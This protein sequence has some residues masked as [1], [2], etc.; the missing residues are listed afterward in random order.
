M[1]KA[2][3]T[4][5]S[6]RSQPLPESTS[7]TPIAP[8]PSAPSSCRAEKSSHDT[9]ID[10]HDTDIDTKDPLPDNTSAPA[11]KVIDKTLALRLIIA[12]LEGSKNCDWYDLSVRMNRAGES[13][14]GGTGA[15]GGKGKTKPKGAKGKGKGRKV[16]AEESE[17]EY[18]EGGVGEGRGKGNKGKKGAEGEW[19]GAELHDLYHNVS[20]SSCI[21][22]SVS[23]ALTHDI[24]ATQLIRTGRPSSTED[25]STALD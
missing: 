5:T 11:G 3:T 25:R 20:P 16:K 15:A 12:K 19:S 21:F 17:D 6:T 13:K 8:K 23:V 22:R 4:S 10:T 9:D 14:E 24:R 18:I 7:K 2:P 1:P